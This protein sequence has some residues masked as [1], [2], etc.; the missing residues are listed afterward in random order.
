LLISRRGAFKDAVEDFDSAIDLDHRRAPSL[1]GRGLARQR[2]GDTKGA[3]A[4]IADAETIDASVKAKL[5]QQT[6]PAQA[7]GQ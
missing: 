1:V 3:H 6:K 2:M 4:D 5:V 7:K